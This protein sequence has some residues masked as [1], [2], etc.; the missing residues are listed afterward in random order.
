M[1]HWTT[2]VIDFAFR[3]RIP[4]SRIEGSKLSTSRIRHESNRN[5]SNF[6]FFNGHGSPTA[7][8]GNRIGDELIKSSD[9][10]IL[11]NSLVFARACDCLAVLGKKAVKDGCTAFIGYKKKFWVA[12]LNS[13]LSRPLHD[14]LAKPI[15]KNSNII[16]NELIKGQ[17]V[18]NAVLAAHHDAADVILKL[19]YSSDP[20]DRSVL[21]SIVTNDQNL[22]FEGDA[23]ATLT[24]I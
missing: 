1:Y 8:Y 7:M 11:K 16:A 14:P 4:V 19:I 21:W 20:N 24:L 3:K 5:K 2:E 23:N 17:S 22:D 15:M 10:D 13:M 6:F 18:E 12:Q 9:T